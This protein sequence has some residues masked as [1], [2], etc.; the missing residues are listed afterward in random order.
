M[1]VCVYFTQ[2]RK[3]SRLQL[4]LGLQRFAVIAMLSNSS[5]KNDSLLLSRCHSVVSAFSFSSDESPMFAVKRETPV[6]S[7]RWLS[8][9]DPHQAPS[10]SSTP[11]SSGHTI[12][13][14]SRN[15]PSDVLMIFI[16]CCIA[17]MFG[18]AWSVYRYHLFPGHGTNA[19]Q[20][21]ML[22]AEQGSK[23]HTQEI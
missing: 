8:D 12:G 4:A 18:I 2:L 14:I 7:P 10:I 20:D 6:D 22:E 23:G 13:S 3:P 19:K 9:V 11:S 21:R 17:A 1:C 5:F 15:D 16:V